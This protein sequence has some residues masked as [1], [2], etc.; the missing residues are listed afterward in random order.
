MIRRDRIVIRTCDLLLK[1]AT[2]QTRAR[3]RVGMRSAAGLIIDEDLLRR[4]NFPKEQTP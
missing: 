2:D 3:V 4:A 1:L